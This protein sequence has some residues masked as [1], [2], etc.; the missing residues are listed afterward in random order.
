MEVVRRHVTLT[1][2]LLAEWCPYIGRRD[3]MNIT[4]QE[5]MKGGRLLIGSRVDLQTLRAV[6]KLA[7]KNRRSV[8]AEVN[9]AIQKHL[10]AVPVDG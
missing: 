3:G 2:K 6:E 9:Y 5:R 8:S 4:T 1:W 7:R 10:G